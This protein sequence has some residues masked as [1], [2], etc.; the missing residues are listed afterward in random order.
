MCTRILWS[1]GGAPGAGVVLVGRSMD[2]YED[3]ATDLWAFPRGM[4]HAQS[5]E[6]MI[7][8]TSRY[9]S[10]VSAMYNA[11]SVDGLNEVGL[12]ANGLYLTEADYGVRDVSRPGVGLPVVIQYVLDSFGTVGE[13]V[14]AFSAGLQVVPVLLGG[15]PGTA[16]ISVSD[17]TGDSAII[18][19][20]DGRTTIH[21]GPEYTIM[22][23]SPPFDEQLA[24]LP[25]YED[26]GGTLALP[27]AV[28]SPARFVRATHFMKLLPATTSARKAVASVL[29]V[30]RN[31]SVPFGEHDPEHPNIAATRWRVVASPSERLYFFDSTIAPSLFWL[32]L[33]AID[34]SEGAPVLKLD[35]QSGADRAGD[36]TA[37]LQ[38]SAPLL[39]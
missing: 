24:L 6:N 29:G 9:G 27:G 20:L 3:T 10:V 34:F 2:W 16:H 23:N 19:F 13:V 11:F 36:V 37:E 7:A 4:K 1:T 17:A 38:P 14:D 35:L 28:D 8:W 18:E 33:A 26:F 39:R 21:H 22:A 25:A 32:D 30:V 12:V 5:G 31:V 15:E